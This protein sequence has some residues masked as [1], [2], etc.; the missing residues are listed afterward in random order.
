[1]PAATGAPSAKA[2]PSVVAP[3]VAS[4]TL[5]PSASVS[6]PSPPDI[7]DKNRRPASGARARAADDQLVRGRIVAFEH[8]VQLQPAL[9]AD[10]IAVDRERVMQ[11]IADIH[12]VV[13]HIYQAGIVDRHQLRRIEGSDAIAEGISGPDSARLVD[14]ERPGSGCG[15]AERQ[16]AGAVD[17]GHFRPVAKL[18]FLPVDDVFRMIARTASIVV[19]RIL[20]HERVGPQTAVDPLAG[21]EILLR[22]A[23]E[24]RSIIALAHLDRCG[25]ISDQPGELVIARPHIDRCLDGPLDQAQH[26]VSVTENDRP[27]KKAAVDYRVVGISRARDAV[28]NVAPGI[29]DDDI[30]ARTAEKNCPVDQ[31]A[32]VEREAIV[33]RR[34]EAVGKRAVIIERACAGAGDRDITREARGGIGIDRDG[35]PCKCWTGACPRAVVDA[36]ARFDAGRPSLGIEA[37]KQRNR[38]D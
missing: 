36:G 34:A 20:P 6:A 16:I 17:E 31:A 28:L 15:I 33:V 25:N 29:V 26:V 10:I 1:M 3:A 19:G 14:R 32:V 37:A 2:V 21:A 5:M 38:S 4:T 24:N 35:L 27:G 11:E 18:D 30:L 12:R 8:R 22:Q 7:G 23:S 9:L 13:R